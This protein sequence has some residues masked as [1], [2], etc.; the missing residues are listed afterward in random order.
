M[1][2]NQIEPPAPEHDT[3]PF[4]IDPVIAGVLLA[5]G[6]NLVFSEQHFLGLPSWPFLRPV[7]VGSG[8]IARSVPR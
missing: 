1:P 2:I 6:L 4:W 7:S 3:R 8:I 5:Q